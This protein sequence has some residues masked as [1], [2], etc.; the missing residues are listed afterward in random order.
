MFQPQWSFSLLVGV[1]KETLFWSD[2]LKLF[3]I[4]YQTVSQKKRKL[5]FN[6]TLA[7][8]ASYYFI[9]IVFFLLILKITLGVNYWYYLHFID[10]KTCLNSQ[11]KWLNLS[12][13][14]GLIGSQDYVFPTVSAASIPA[15][16]HSH[17]SHC[18][19]MS[20]TSHPLTHALTHSSTL[21]HPFEHSNLWT[22]M[23]IDTY[24][25]MDTHPHKWMSDISILR[26]PASWGSYFIM[27]SYAQWGSPSLPPQEE[28]GW[29]VEATWCQVLRT[30]M[31]HRSYTPPC[32][33]LCNI[34]TP[35]LSWRHSN[36]SY[37]R[38]SG[39]VP[40]VGMMEALSWK[41]TSLYF[42][43]CLLLWWDKDPHPQDFNYFFCHRVYSYL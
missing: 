13:T 15:P 18:W 30:H 8:I 35:Q 14:L 26:V 7:N 36:N 24:L 1:L 31:I 41:P 20:L 19:S 11:S 34:P 17:Q 21:S 16:P 9:Y 5:P 6:K 29:V 28:L 40:S 10:N 3:L 2:E 27:Y 33:T 12:S 37:P 39:Y 23:H 22:L 38:E 25:L 4:F 42:Q 32:P 43:A